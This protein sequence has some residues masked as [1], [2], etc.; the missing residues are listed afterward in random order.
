MKPMLDDIELMAKILYTLA[1]LALDH[2]DD[3]DR[4]KRDAILLCIQDQAKDLQDA[5]QELHDAMQ[6]MKSENGVRL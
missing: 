4:N 6:A 3:D 1:D 5:V 2:A